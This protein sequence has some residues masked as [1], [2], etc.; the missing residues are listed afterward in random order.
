MA[1]PTRQAL[2][3]LTDLVSESANGAK[4]TRILAGT[5]GF[6][7]KEWRG[8][9]YPPD[10]PVSAMLP[11]YAERFPAVEINNTF[12]KLPNENM[13]AEWAEQVPATFRFVLKAS[14]RI[15][16]MKRLKEVEEPLEYLLTVSAALGEKR[17]P[18][19]F[20]LPPNMKK[21]VERL[22]RF[23]D[24]LPSAMRAAF[25]FRHASWFEDEVYAVLRAHGTALCVADTDENASPLVPTADWGYLRLRRQGYDERGLSEW[26]KRIAAQ[27]WSEAWVFFKHEDEGT[28][29]ALARR[30]L[31]VPGATASE[32][33]P[34]AGARYRRSTHPGRSSDNKAGE[35]EESESVDASAGLESAIAAMFAGPIESFVTRRDSLAKE[36]R[37]AGRRDD[38][39][40]VKTLRKPAR[41]AWALDVAAQ[42]DAERI[43][44]V[45]AA[46]EATLIAQSGGG[47]LRGAMSELRAA[48]G[49]LAGAASRAAAERGQTVDRSAL[50]NAVMAVIGNPGAFDGLRA[51]RLVDIP[52]AGGLDSLTSFAPVP[53]ASSPATNE[54]EGDG[55]AADTAVRAA[56]RQAEAALAAARERSAAAQCGL[57]IAE[58]NAEKADRSLRLAQEQ[59]RDRKVELDRARQE[60]RVAAEEL[61]GAE[62]AAAD[63]RGASTR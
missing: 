6:S 15:T 58:V 21:D 36:L 1:G 46:V 53:A 41:M 11:Y 29:P 50:V 16:H 62:R 38:A 20:Q 25:E 60:A 47:D 37:A 31:D 22:A 7:Y 4:A 33:I 10:L 14:Q 55:V 32:S 49:D 30:F 27:P 12:Y 57:E 56:Q 34:V 9:F 23:L 43:E 5:S 2:P 61:L 8:R 39:A 45:A 28:G 42:S 52:E 17:G 19:L 59:A 13:L 35:M 40:R 48:V 63:T 24:L 26:R 51:G 18:F 44:R 54:S 3:E